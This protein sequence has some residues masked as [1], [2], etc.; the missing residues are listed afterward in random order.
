MQKSVI[1]RHVFCNYGN[2]Y[3]NLQL[4]LS[5]KLITG[6]SFWLQNYKKNK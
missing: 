2:I 4:E 3:V 5:S 1:F 6:A